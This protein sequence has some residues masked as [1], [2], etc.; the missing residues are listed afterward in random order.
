MTSTVDKILQRWKD[1]FGI[2]T[3]MMLNDRMP[4][5]EMARI[6]IEEVRKEDVK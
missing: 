4:Y 1:R 6:A 5:S 3:D 2:T